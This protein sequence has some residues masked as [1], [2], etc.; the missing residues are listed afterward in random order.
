MER[1]GRDERK[2]VVDILTDSFDTN[3]SVNYVVNQDVN[4][5]D[6]VRSLM[7]YSFDMCNAFGEVWL[8]NDQRAC[9]LILFKDKQKTTISTILWDIKLALKVIGLSRVSKVLGR[10]SKIKA[11]HPKTPFAYLWFVGVKQESQNRRIGSTL[12]SELIGRYSSQKRPIYL[13]TSV[14]RNLPWYKKHGFHIYQTIPLSYN[15][16]LLRREV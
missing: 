11:F 9:A 16:Y 2:L 4:R 10:E 3:K 8:S 13:E 15:L 1:A 7:E 12:L 6:R 14:D 5:K